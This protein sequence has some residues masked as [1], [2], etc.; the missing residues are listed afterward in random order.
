MRQHYEARGRLG[1]ALHLQVRGMLE[2]TEPQ[3][4]RCVLRK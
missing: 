4:G 2:L 1:E 3:M